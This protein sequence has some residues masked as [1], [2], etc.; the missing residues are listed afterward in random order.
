MTVTSALAPRRFVAPEIAA[1]STNDAPTRY[2]RLQNALIAW[3]DVAAAGA[4]LRYAE[5]NEIV[6][7]LPD[8]GALLTSAETQIEAPARSIC[9]LPPGPCAIEAKGPGR[10]IQVFAPLPV[11]L[12]ALS[13][14]TPLTT[15][16]RGVM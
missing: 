1:A 3:S 7:V 8:A 13:R 12:A 9:I 10:V 11:H 6:A 16:R 5:P 2:M 15:K 14:R 4:V